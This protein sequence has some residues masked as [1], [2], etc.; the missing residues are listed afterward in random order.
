MDEQ[1][2]YI[3]IRVL[4]QLPFSFYFDFLMSNLCFGFVMFVPRRKLAYCLWKL[5]Q[6]GVYLEEL[7]LIALR[8]LIDV[9]PPDECRGH[10][11]S[12][13]CVACKQ[14]EHE[15]E[16]LWKNEDY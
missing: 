4:K 15:L 7:P 1:D 12:C 5:F 10:S 2:P 8:W 13:R 9:D 11:P 14:H 16:K 6:W 3:L